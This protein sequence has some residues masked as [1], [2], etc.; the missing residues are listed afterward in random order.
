MPT[1]AG[2]DNARRAAI[3]AQATKGWTNAQLAKA[4]GTDPATIRDFL[5][6]SRWPKPPT[7]AKLDEAFGWTPGTLA[8]IGEELLDAP[9]P[10]NVGPDPDDEDSLLFRRP[11]G[12]TDE[13]WR[14]LK[15]RKRGDWKWEVLRAAEER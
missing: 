9:E 11:E 8:A 10:H 1:P 14:R 7:L 12:L 6:G 13:Q 3:A 2:H 5:D 4:A 15:E